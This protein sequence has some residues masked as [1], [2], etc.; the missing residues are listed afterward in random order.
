M[1]E[2]VV[3]Q[4]FKNYRKGEIISDEAEI[5]AILASHHAHHV[6]KIMAR[7]QTT[8]ARAAAVTTPATKASS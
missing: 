7:S 3:K 2:L 8:A 4:K 5:A 1:Y 6:N